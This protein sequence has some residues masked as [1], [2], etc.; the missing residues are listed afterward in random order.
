MYHVTFKGLENVAFEF[1]PVAFTIP[2]FSFDLF[3]KTFTFAEKPMYWYG[4]LIVIGMVLSA[5]YAFRRAKKF[6]IKADHMYDYAIF[7]IIFGVIGARLYYVLT[8][9]DAYDSIGEA[10][11]IWNGGLAIYGGV[12]AGALVVIIVSKIK[13]INP[14][15]VLDAVAPAV[16]IG[17]AIGRWGN[18]MNQ[19]AFGCNTTLPWGMKST[20]VAGSSHSLT[21]T[22]EYLQRQQASLA[23]LGIIVDPQGF[24]HPTFLYESLWNII[25]FIIIH[26]LYKKRT[27]KGEMV[28]M[29]L[30]WYG[31]GRAFIEMLRTDS[32]YIPGTEIRISALVGALCFVFG[33]ATLIFMKL[34]VKKHPQTLE[35][36]LVSGPKEAEEPDD[37]TVDPDEIAELEAIDGAESGDIEAPDTEEEPSNGDDNKDIT[38]D[39]GEN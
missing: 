34:R 7:T 29:Y 39:G 33:L 6:G 22:V 14:L 36:A 26:F 10:L 25:G 35:T 15:T 23:E 3:G 11:A 4:I 13:K 28:L 38:N 37:D 20:V 31:L 19:E 8:N 1:S 12:I 17:Q 18:F 27:F 9:L 21:G 16:M 30:T 2:G 5:I 32:L 24:V